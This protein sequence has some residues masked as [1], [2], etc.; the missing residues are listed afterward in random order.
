MD[1]FPVFWLAQLDDELHDCHVPEL[2]RGRIHECECGCTWEA[3]RAF[4]PGGP[5]LRWA[6]T[7]DPDR[8]GA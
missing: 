1:Q 6:L 5:R 7:R 3:L 8:A 2:R 4:G